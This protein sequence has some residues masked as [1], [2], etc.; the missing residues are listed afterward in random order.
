MSIRLISV[1]LV[2]VAICIAAFAMGHELAYWVMVTTGW[3]PLR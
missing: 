3:L 1:V 2:V